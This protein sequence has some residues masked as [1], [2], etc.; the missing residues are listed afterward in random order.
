MFTDELFFY[1]VKLSYKYILIYTYTYI[2]VN[3]FL[4]FYWAIN[5]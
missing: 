3:W 2:N 5:V 1:Q 4:R